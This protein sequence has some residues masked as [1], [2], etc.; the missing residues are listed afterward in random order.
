M[1]LSEF[2]EESGMTQ[3]NLARRAKVSQATVCKVLNGHDCRLSI[4]MRIFKATK[5]QVTPEELFFPLHEHSDTTKKKKKKKH[6]GK[7]K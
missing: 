4:A 5:G 2:F 7:T 1:K 3:A 6:D